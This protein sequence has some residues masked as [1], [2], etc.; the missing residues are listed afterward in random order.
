MRKTGSVLLEL[1][2]GEEFHN[3]WYPEIVSND[4]EDLFAVCQFFTN[5]PQSGPTFPPLECP[6]SVRLA[7]ERV[8]FQNFV[9]EEAILE[10]GNCLELLLLLVKSFLLL[11]VKE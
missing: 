4:R 8:D 11:D 9:E 3:E 6:D 1:T 2:I 7:V 10:E 5:V